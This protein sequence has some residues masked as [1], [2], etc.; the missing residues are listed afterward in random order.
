[1]K[2][3]IQVLSDERNSYEFR[4]KNVD[5]SLANALRRTILADISCVVFNIESKTDCEFYKNTT[6]FHNEILKERLRAI[7]VHCDDNMEEWASRHYVEIDISNTSN[8]YHYI[9]TEHFKIKRVDGSGEISADE[10]ESIFPKN[11]HQ[12]Y[13][14]FVRMSPFIH[15]NI[16]PEQLHFRC[17][18][19]VSSARKNGC[20]SV[21]SKCSYQNTISIEQGLEE[22]SKIEKRLRAELKDE[23]PEALEKRIE[24]EKRDFNYLDAQRYFIANSFDFIVQ[25]VGVFTPVEIVSK[26]CIVLQNQC[27]DLIENLKETPETMIFLSGSTRDYSTIENAYDV[28]LV[29]TLA[30]LGCVLNY[31]LLANYFYNG[32]S[33]QKESK[34]NNKLSFCAFKKVHPHDP[35]HVLRVAFNEKT[36]SNEVRDTL[37]QCAT[38]ISK[39]YEHLYGLFAG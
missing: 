28:L 38:N 5:V 11:E 18:F 2:P 30:S 8:E 32:E 15:E 26:A 16:V 34:T 21:V 9:T 23:T 1:M 33:E 3:S 6:R 25:G 7:P 19:M 39:V 27:V 22:W 12:N 37:I 20:F 17:G 35:Y 4:I 29:G 13:I 24:F 10:R 14:D 36:T 31:Y